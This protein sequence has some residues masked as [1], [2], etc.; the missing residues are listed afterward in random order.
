[1][2]PT[3]NQQTPYQTTLATL[4]LSQNTSLQELVIISFSLLMIQRNK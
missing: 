3:Y 2:F 1:M 4:I